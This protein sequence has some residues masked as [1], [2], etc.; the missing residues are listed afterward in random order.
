MRRT[1]TAIV[2]SC[3]AGRIARPLYIEG[4]TIVYN[5]MTAYSYSAGCAAW[6]LI[7]AVIVICA[8][9]FVVPRTDHRSPLCD[10]DVQE[11]YNRDLVRPG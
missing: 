7:D 2:Y 6:L 3:R 5:N 11:R 10:L 4:G 8:R 1:A 9:H